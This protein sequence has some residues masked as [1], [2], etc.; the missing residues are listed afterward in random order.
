MKFCMEIHMVL[1]KQNANL[2]ELPELG[3]FYLPASAGHLPWEASP[4]V[5]VP[6]FGGIFG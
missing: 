2:S 1:R 6:P 3:V 5:G 4:V